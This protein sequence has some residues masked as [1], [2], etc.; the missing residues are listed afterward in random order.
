MSKNT[1]IKDIKNVY[2]RTYELGK[3]SFALSTTKTT[4][5]KFHEFESSGIL[6]ETP[7]EQL[8][9]FCSLSLNPQDWLDSERFF[10]A[11]EKELKND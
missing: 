3:Q 8:R 9:F 5:K 10:D 6:E 7:L 4:L 2:Y 11:I 1:K